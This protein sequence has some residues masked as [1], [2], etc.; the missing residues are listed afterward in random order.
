[1]K[2]KQKI[3]GIIAL[4]LVIVVTAVLTHV[5]DK[6][7]VKERY[8]AARYHAYLM[9]MREKCP[10]A[11]TAYLK[12]YED[13][14]YCSDK[15]RNELKEQWKRVDQQNEELMIEMRKRIKKAEKKRFD[16]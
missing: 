6:Y 10:N 8:Y 14:M 16:E 1:M 13:C 2:R 3:R 9:F 5:A 15:F 12:G 4:V 7:F 11:L